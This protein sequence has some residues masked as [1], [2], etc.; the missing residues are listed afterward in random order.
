MEFLCPVSGLY[1]PTSDIDLVV[2]GAGHGGNVPG[3][4]RSLAAMLSKKEIA[5]N[6]QV[7]WL[8]F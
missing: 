8:V 2:L 4:L 5:T 6:I 7:R 3:A 1:V